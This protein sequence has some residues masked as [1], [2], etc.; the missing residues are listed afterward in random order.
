MLVTIDLLRAWNA[1]PE[2][3]EMFACVFPDGVEVTPENL[4]KASI[5]QFSVGWFALGAAR[6]KMN[7][8]V[9]PA[10]ASRLARID[11]AWMQYRCDHLSYE[12]YTA[13]YDAAWA[14]FAAIE[15]PARD[16]Y[17]REHALVS[18]LILNNDWINLA[19]YINEVNKEDIDE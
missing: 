11:T 1:C 4:E 7:E 12:D 13:V 2:E 15:Q 8:I 5:Y 19:A 14:E 18:A 3:R 6:N 10:G 16:I 9:F 17:M